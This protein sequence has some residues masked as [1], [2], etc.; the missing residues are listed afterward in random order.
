[1]LCRQQ[2]QLLVASTL[3]QHS[4]AEKFTNV[5][6]GIWTWA[7]TAVITTGGNT[8][9]A[10]ARETNNI[11][12]LAKTAAFST[13]IFPPVV[14]GAASSIQ[15]SQSTICSHCGHTYIHTFMLTY[16]HTHTEYTHGRTHTNAWTLKSVS[17]VFLLIFAC[18]CFRLLRGLCV[19][20]YLC[21][22]LALALSH[23]D[24]LRHAGETNTNALQAAGNVCLAWPL[25]L[26]WP[27]LSPLLFAFTAPPQRQLLS[28]APSSIHINVS[29]GDGSNVF[30]FF[31]ASF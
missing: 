11:Y 14:V 20:V 25:S 5:F 13:Y 4:D 7:L 26:S 24:S 8:A 6:P 28:R 2:Q 17:H 10:L 30:F 31:F 22:H 3:P 16:T 9:G 1:M 23:L 27:H 15:R 12:T 19:C 29:G 18:V 21:E